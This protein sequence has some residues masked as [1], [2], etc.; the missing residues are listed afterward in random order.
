MSIFISYS[1][2]SP[3]RPRHR[4]AY[5]IGTPRS[6]VWVSW[7]RLPVAARK[8]EEVILLPKRLRKGMPCSLKF[9]TPNTSACGFPPSAPAISPMFATA[10]CPSASAVTKPV[11]SGYLSK[12]N[13]MPVFKARPFPQLL[14]CVQTSHA[15]LLFKSSKIAA[16]S[17][18]LPSST[19]I[20]CR[21]FFC[22][23]STNK[24]NFSSGL[25]ARMIT[26]GFILT[27]PNFSVRPTVAPFLVLIPF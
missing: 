24:I 25:R 3:V 4:S 27:P 2:L 14:G 22:S 10:C 9:R 11:L 1:Y 16:Y 26:T 21:S 17:A 13:L 19:T 15:Y 20:V 12:R 23:S 8:I 5:C 18:P 6:P 7:Q